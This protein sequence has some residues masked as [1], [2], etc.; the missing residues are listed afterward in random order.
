MPRIKTHKQKRKLLAI[1][2]DLQVDKEICH[3]YEETVESES[4]T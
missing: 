4:H 2:H 3:Q 1:F